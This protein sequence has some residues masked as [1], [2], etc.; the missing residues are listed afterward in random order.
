MQ[1]L[2]TMNKTLRGLVLGGASLSMLLSPWSMPIAAS[3]TAPSRPQIV[4]AIGN[5]QSMD[6]DLSG[7]IMTGS[8]LLSKSL[9]S[10]YN[11]SS[12]QNYVI[13]SGFVPPA[14]APAGSASAP[15]TVKA[16]NGTLVDNSASRLNVAKAG[17]YTVLNQYLPSMDFALETY[18]TS[19]PPS[20][21]STW[22]YYMSGPDGFSFKNDLPTNGFTT[23][24]DYQNFVDNPT[25]ANADPAATRWVLN[26]CF[27]Y[28]SASSNVAT[29]C[30][31]IDQAGALPSGQLAG[32]KYMQIAASSDDPDIN[33]VLYAG[34]GTDPLSLD[35]GGAYAAYNFRTYLGAITA[36]KT[37]YTYFSLSDYNV[38]A[39]SVGYNSYTDGNTYMTGPTNAGYVPYSPQ[40]M[41]AQRGFGYSAGQ[42]STTGSTVVQMTTNLDTLTP[43]SSTFQTAYAS[44]LA[45]FQAALAPETNNA[46]TTE[47]K[48]S[49]GQSA[50]AGLVQGAG[51][52]LKGLTASCAGQYVILVTDGLPTSDLKGNAWPPLGSKAGHGYGVNASF[53]GIG[54]D[55]QYGINDDSGNLP[56][57]QTK[58]ALDIAKTNDAALVDAVTAIQKL[59][60]AGIKTY[61]IGLGAGVDKTVNPAASYALNAM[62]I[63]GGT[64]T[65]YPANNVPQFTNALSSIAATIFGNVVA[66]APAVPP[67][68]QSGSLAYL[69]STNNNLGSEQGFFQAFSLD[70]NG[71]VSISPAWTL[72]MTAAQRRADLFTDQGSGTGVSLL[73]NQPASAF[74]NPSTPSA[75]DIINYTIDPSYNN[76]AYLAGRVS[77]SFLGTISS[78]SAKPLILSRPNNPSFLSSSSYRSFA[79]TNSSRAQLELFTTN[80]G[81][82]YAISAGSPSSNGTLQWAWM[83]SV[84]LPQLGNYSGF[85]NAQTMVGGLITVDS[86]DASGNWATYVVGTGQGGGL[87]YDLKLSSCS[88]STSACTPSISSVWFDAQSGYSSAPQGAPQAPVI[89][90]DANDIAYAYYFTTLGST[91]YLNVMRLYDGSTSKVKLGF[92]PSSTSY[93]NS[94]AGQLLVGDTAGNIWSVDLTSGSTASKLSA[95]SLIGTVPNASTAGPLRFIGEA[96]TATGIYVWGTTD[97]QVTVFKFTGGAISTSTTGWTPWWW[98]STSG[99]GYLS[100]TAMATTTADPGVSSTTAPYWLDAGGTITD[101]SGVQADTLVVPVTVSPQASCGTPVAKYDF[102]LLASGLF[103]KGTFYDTNHNAL[104]SNPQIGLGIAYSPVIAQNGNGSAIVYGSAAQNPNGKIGFQVAATSG[105]HVGPGLVGWQPLW[106]T[107]P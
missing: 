85:Q 4:I 57:G 19:Q 63:A 45:S 37:P 8:G 79:Q 22:V 65:V 88:S 62:A 68:V 26:P 58:G 98:S 61:V 39:V 104:T 28:T 48:A 40:V 86:A 73:A 60:G 53:Y 43:G 82:L 47:I 71:N 102:F 50:L 66:A 83:P 6:G 38:G 10:L 93:L 107:Q 24:T 5:S 34:S 11:T 33:D 51:S 74:G 42:S 77:G 56:G 69:L 70:A 9:S 80:D 52:L 105:L 30:S 36:T 94:D 12:P 75:Q 2:R 92:T 103:P 96:E 78:P 55:A 35:Y 27:N 95:P 17:I 1:T 90:W 44:D 87:H 76:G 54:A 89:W 101:A 46:Y 32:D 16:S 25:N 3:A 100:G 15:Y 91:S 23:Y 72:Q 20:Y 31:G 21:W 7:A 81:F 59:A 97:H 14:S 67:Y 29:Y 18:K 41:Y 64:S 49:A 84:L 13:P 106:M 99:S